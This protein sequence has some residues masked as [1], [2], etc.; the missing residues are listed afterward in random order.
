MLLLAIWQVGL[1]RS[2]GK[3]PMSNAVIIG[4]TIFLWLIYF[5][6]IT[7]KLITEVQPNNLSVAMRGIWRSYRISLAAVKPVH[8]VTSDPVSDWAAPVP[9]PQP[10]E[11]H[12]SPAGTKAWSWS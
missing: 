8:T 10:A 2:S 11:R 7:V 3:Q 1:G 4:W 5:R 12:P 6:L 9:D